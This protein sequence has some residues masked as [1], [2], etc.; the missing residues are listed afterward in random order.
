MYIILYYII[1]IKNRLHYFYLY[2]T[3]Y[4]YF[5]K[6]FYFYLNSYYKNLM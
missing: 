5:T 4:I 2:L 6:Y 3:K 1:L